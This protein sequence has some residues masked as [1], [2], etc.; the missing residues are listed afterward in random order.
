M[1]TILVICLGLS[2][3]CNFWLATRHHNQPDTGID[4][5]VLES[6]N[7]LAE[8]NDPEGLMFLGLR[9][10][11]AVNS[12]KRDD[13]TEARW[14]HDAREHILKACAKSDNAVG[15]WTY[16]NQTGLVA[17]DDQ[18]I[19]AGKLIE[20]VEGGIVD[21]SWA[22]GLLGFVHGQDSKIFQKLLGLDLAYTKKMLRQKA[23]SGVREHP[24]AAL[25]LAS[26]LRSFNQE[27]DA[28]IVEKLVSDAV[29]ALEQQGAAW[30]PF[31]YE[32]LAELF[33]NGYGRVVEPDASRASRY[34]TLLNEALAANQNR[35]P[36]PAKQ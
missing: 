3:A 10:L 1:R 30:N 27:G 28:E 35:H 7:R 24:Q 9:A 15:L 22:T 20:M 18:Y 26:H 21:E 36:N 14:R 32:C 4:A 19:E 33:E 25:R 29:A 2:L 11:F 17:P 13:P 23:L 16:F 5:K 8:Q 6:A 34:K 31:A 12:L